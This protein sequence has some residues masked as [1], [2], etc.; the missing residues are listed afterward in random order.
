MDKKAVDAA[1]KEYARAAK[2]ANIIRTSANF[3]EVLV[4]W[5]SFLTAHHR[6]FT[7]LEQGSKSSRKSRAWWG[8]KLC[9]RRKDALLCYLFHARNADEHTVEEITGHH[10]TRTMITEPNPQIVSAMERGLMGRPHSPILRTIETVLKN[11]R[12]LNVVDKGTRFDVPKDH[13]GSP[14]SDTRP[15][16]IASLGVAYLGSMLEEARALTT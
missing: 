5:T 9:Q 2:C 10:E 15:A 4:A 3:E 12:L 16:T 6:V 13:L 1:Q 8:R 11:V 7:K 14:L